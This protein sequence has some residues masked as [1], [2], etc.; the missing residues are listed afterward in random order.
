[1]LNTYIRYGSILDEQEKPVEAGFTSFMKKHYTCKFCQQN[2]IFNLQE[3]QQHH[4]QC[5]AR[6]RPKEPEEG[7]SQQKTQQTTTTSTARTRHYCEKCDKTFVFTP[8]EILVH[9]KQ[10]K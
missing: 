3:I 10:H 6:K 9:A 4:E 2:F 5:T 8:T 7:P 1:M